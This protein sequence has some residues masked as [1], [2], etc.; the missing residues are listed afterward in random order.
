MTE[1]KKSEWYTPAHGR[2]SAKYIKDKRATMSLLMM[3][4][5]KEQIKAAADALDISMNAYILEAVEHKIDADI[6]TGVIPNV[7]E[8]ITRAELLERKQARM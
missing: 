2:A 3:P 5:V 1:N 6:I 4:E 7:R 8:S